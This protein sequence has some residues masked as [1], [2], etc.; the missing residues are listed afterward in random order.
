[1]ATGAVAA[2]AGADGGT[3]VR[4]AGSMLALQVSIGALN[5]VVDAPLDAGEKRGK[6]LARGLVGP[7]TALWLAGLAGVMGLALSAPS[8]LGTFAVA[9]A[10]LGLGYLY[11]LRLSRTRWSWAPL[12]LALP[13]LPIHAWL[14][15]TGSV[16]PGLVTLLPAAALA[17]T[18]LAVANGLVDVERDVRAGRLA[19]AVEL[20]P[21]LAWTLHTAPLAIVALLAV[22]VAPAV[23]GGELLPGSPAGPPPGPGGGTGLPLD[24]LRLLRTAGVGL[25]VASLAVGALVLTA[26]RAEIRERGWEMEAVGVAAI[27]LGWLGGIA[28]TTAG[29]E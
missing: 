6:P 26:R 28:G 19:V 10:G 29:G 22:F 24:A 20:G 14:G 25:G 13:L 11:D 8:G 16:P 15:A 17:G 9:G 23:P 2:L 3:A 1:M 7:R 12:S 27:G 5:D 18:A 21:R 4:L